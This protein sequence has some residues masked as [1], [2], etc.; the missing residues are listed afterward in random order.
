MNGNILLQLKRECPFP[1]VFQDVE[2]CEGSAFPVPHRKIGHIRAD[3]D[4][5]R[6]YNTVW[7]CHREFET[8]EIVREIDRTYAALTSG[9]ALA[10]LAAL[11]RFC[12]A[13]PEACIDQQYR[14]EYDFF[15]EGETCVFWLRLITRE[16]DYNLYLHAFT[17]KEEEG[18]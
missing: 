13:H 1:E 4:G 11:K 6:W 15:L 7:H 16:K 10:D 3:Y 2:T 12:E 14:Q 18:A 17:K 5:L 9:D 8:S